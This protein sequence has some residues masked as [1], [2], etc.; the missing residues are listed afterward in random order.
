[1][2]NPAPPDPQGDRIARATERVRAASETASQAQEQL[3]L[4]RERVAQ[5]RRAL[6]SSKTGESV[7]AA[8]DVNAIGLDEP[9]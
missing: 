5:A 2:G 7:R 8:T 9:Q 1:M 4:A 6:S 3:A